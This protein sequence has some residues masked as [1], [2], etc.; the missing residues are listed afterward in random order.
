MLSSYEFA[1]T[2]IHFS[3]KTALWFRSKGRAKW[4]SATA[5]IERCIHWVY[6]SCKRGSE[7][8]L[9]CWCAAKAVWLADVSEDAPQTAQHNNE[10]GL[11]VCLSVAVSHFIRFTHSSNGPVIINSLR[12]LLRS[13]Q[14]RMIFLWMRSQDSWRD[15][16]SCWLQRICCIMS[17]LALYKWP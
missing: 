5:L 11:S 12:R 16:F 4:S 17:N 9:M 2:T 6:G 8:E 1:M 7:S 13:H 14:T 15:L 10:P 3:C